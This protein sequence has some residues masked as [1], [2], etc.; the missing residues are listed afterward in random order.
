MNIINEIEKDYLQFCK[1]K[2]IF[3]FP[4]YIPKSED[5]P[6]YDIERYSF[7]RIRRK[8]RRLFI[9]KSL[10]NIP[11]GLK[12][13]FDKICKDILEGND[14]LRYQSRFLKDYDFNDKMLADWGVQHFHLSTKVEHDGYVKRTNE[15]LFLRITNDEAYLIGIFNHGE[16]EKIDIVEILHSEWP[17]S[18]KHFKMNR[19]QSIKNKPTSSDIKLLRKNID[20]IFPSSNCC[21]DI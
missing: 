6:M 14:L 13:A 8:K 21:Y 20:N 5:S 2:L 4:D 3:L 18:I 19:I 16:W 11:S 12:N 1:K 9:S 17:E 7:R 15:L 10:N